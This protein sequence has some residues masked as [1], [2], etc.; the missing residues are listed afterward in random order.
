M[1]GRFIGGGIA[2]NVYEYLPD[3]DFVVKVEH[4]A[5]SFQNAMEW[6]TWVEVRET[7]WA[8][9]FA[10]CKTISMN[11]SVL[12]QRKTHPLPPA[13]R[14]MKLPNFLTDLKRQ[15]FGMIDDQVVAHDYGMTLLFSKAFGAARMK[16]VE[17]DWWSTT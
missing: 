11:G 12:I 17:R 5:Y 9:W 8:K 14:P 3:L 4:R 10:P 6:E 1:V 15:N 16:N 13:L 2:R 7:K